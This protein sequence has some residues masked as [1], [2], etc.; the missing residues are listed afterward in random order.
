MKTLIWF[1]FG[2]SIA[3][4]VGLLCSWLLSVGCY[5]K[6]SDYH[7]QWGFF[8]ECRI[9]FEGKLTPADQVNFV[10]I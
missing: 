6:Y 3:I 9:V 4:A 10:Q 8:S 7:P 1:E 5:Q 2:L